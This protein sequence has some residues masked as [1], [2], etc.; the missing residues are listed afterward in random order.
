MDTAMFLPIVAA[1]SLDTPPGL[2]LGNP[3]LE[4][5]LLKISVAKQY[6]FK[7]PK[8]P[9]MYLPAMLRPA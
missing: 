9:A 4:R 6:V 2:V 1:I 8:I 5:L 7:M 3:G